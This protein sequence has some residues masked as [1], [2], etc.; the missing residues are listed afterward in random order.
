VN[1]VVILYS[2]SEGQTEKV[3]DYLAS[4]IREQDIEVQ[5][6]RIEKSSLRGPQNNTILDAVTQC[7]Y[8]VVGGS[9]HAGSYQSVLRKFVKTHSL[10]L[11]EK[12]NALFTIALSAQGAEADTTGK[13][14]LEDA[15]RSFSD[16]SGWIPEKHVTFAGARRYTR[17]NPVIRHMMKKI[18]ERSGGDTDTS[19]DYEYTDWNDVDA[20]AASI[21]AGMRS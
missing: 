19:K 13:K 2:T 14:A 17:Y 8:V 16:A 9:I 5:V 21:V 11:S 3:A 4:R 7:G 6:F 15:V 1:T 20:F 10:L 18:A 12:R